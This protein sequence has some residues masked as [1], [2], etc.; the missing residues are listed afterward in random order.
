MQTSK[1]CRK[2]KHNMTSPWLAFLVF[3]LMMVFV[4][5]GCGV[6]QSPDQPPVNDSP[7]VVVTEEPEESPV[8]SSENMNSNS[9]NLQDKG[10]NGM[11]TEAEDKPEPADLKKAPVDKNNEL[12]CTLTVSAE[13]ILDNMD[14]LDP[15]KKEVLPEDGT[16]LV[17]QTVIFYEGESVFDV[18]LRAAKEGKI[19]MEF[20]SVPF[21]NSK[22][23]EGIGN[24]Y[25]YDCGEL[26]GW[27]YKVNDWFPNYGCSQYPVKEGDQIQWLY[28]CDLGRDI[29]GDWEAQNGR[30]QE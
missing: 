6:G 15:A 22:Y 5:S 11:E 8:P 30:D 18:L 2:Q 29:G 28:T 17:E 13:T 26:S 23:I 20:T 1:M 24:L 27:M 10:Q 16:L 14:R 25:E 19:H 21:Y 7:G 4:L 12:L 3:A 9:D